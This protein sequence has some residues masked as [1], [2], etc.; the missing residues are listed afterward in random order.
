MVQEDIDQ[1]CL[2]FRKMMQG[3]NFK[4]VRILYDYGHRRHAETKNRR[5]ST[6]NLAAYL[7]NYQPAPEGPMAQAH[8]GALESLAILGDK[9][10]PRKEKSTHHGSGSRHRLKDARDDIT[11][12]RIDKARR[13]RAAREGYDSDD[14][15]ETQEYDGEMR[16]VDCLAYKIWET[17]PPKRFKPNPIDAAKYDG[18][19]EPRSWIDDYLQTVIL[20]KGNQIAAM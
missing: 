11:Q 13:R 8:R 18:Q 3:D 20:H 14:S 15:E 12:S 5:G 7:I 2:G 17:M 1:G 19:Q 9:L 6:A 16:G 4:L 10:V